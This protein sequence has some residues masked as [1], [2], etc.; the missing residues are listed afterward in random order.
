MPGTWEDEM[1]IDTSRDPIYLTKAEWYM[2]FAISE[3]WNIP[4]R[5][6]LRMLIEQEY[7]TLGINVEE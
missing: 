2:L 5:M 1:L 7:S 6:A 3:Q 4:E